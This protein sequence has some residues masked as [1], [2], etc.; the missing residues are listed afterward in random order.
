MRVQ[1]K[2]GGDVMSRHI[3]HAL[4]PA[5]CYLGNRVCNNVAVKRNQSQHKT[6]KRVTLM[7][8]REYIGYIK[9]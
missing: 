1:K 4:L 5:F 3:E 7:G 2:G 8:Y 6:T 9:G